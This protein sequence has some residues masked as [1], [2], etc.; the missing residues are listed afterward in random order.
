M[1]TYLTKLYNLIKINH[2]TETEYLEALKAF[3]NSI[4]ELVETDNQIEQLSIIERLV[5]PD[6]IIS[7][8][9]PWVDDLGKIR[10]NTGYRVQFNN[11]IGPYKGGIRFSPTVNQSILKM[12]AF[13]QTFK[14]S[15]TGLPLGGA[16]GGADFNPK[17]KSDLEIMR[18]CQSF[19]LELSKYIGPSIDVPAGDLGVSQKEIGYL[20]G[21]YKKIK[22]THDGTLT[23]KAPTYGG[24][25]ARPEATGYGLVYIAEKALNTYYNES[26]KNKDVII[27]GTGQVAI[28]AAYKAKELGAKV[29]A[30]SSS[31]GMVYDFKGID[32]NLMQELK[33]NNITID[34]YLKTHKHATFS[35]NNKDIWEIKADIILP[36]ATQGEINVLDIEKIIKNKPLIIVEGANKPLSNDAIALLIKNKILFIPAKAANAGG[37]ATSS[38]EMTQNATNSV[39]S[40]AEVDQKLKSKMENIFNN[41]YLT[42]TNLDELYNLEKAANITAFNKLYMA[43]KALGV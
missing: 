7:F 23:G 3:L 14:N 41:I 5:V 36:S 21:M 29:I 16:K 43:M 19:M 15:L 31:V 34:N 32:I 10:V 30:M 42:A 33:A 1:H 2:P 22:S 40:F 8:K 12:L 6:R 25:F 39:W 9:V 37:V 38:F 26:F 4:T 17:D 18:F 20:Y 35:N 13:E 27:S 11:L 28:H 24:S